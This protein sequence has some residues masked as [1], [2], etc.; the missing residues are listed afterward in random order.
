MAH[1]KPRQI[2]GFTI[3]ELMIA[4]TLGLILGGAVIST[5][6][7]TRQSYTQDEAVRRMQDDARNAVRELAKDLQMAGFWADLVFPDAITPDGDSLDAAGA[8]DCGPAGTPDWLY[9]LDDAITF[10]DNATGASANASFSCIASGDIVPGTDVIAIKRLV[11]ATT[12]SPDENAHVR[13]NGTLGLLYMDEVSAS[14]PVA[15]PAPFTEWEYRPTIYYVRDGGILG[16]EGV[17]TLC[18]KTLIDGDLVDECLA[19]GIENLQI[20]LGLDTSGNGEPNVFVANPTAAELETAVAARIYV[21]ARSAEPDFRYTNEKT[22]TIGNAPDH[23]PDDNFYRRVH[24]V[25]V[26]MHNLANL[27]LLRDL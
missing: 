19:L 17:P 8:P 14:P 10:V 11:G 22:Y 9:D 25:T 21:L 18:R 13:T 26:R 1:C 20:E 12:A 16:S 24:S 3:I 4:M 2:S 23:A 27:R 5:F 15:V 6:V 7:F